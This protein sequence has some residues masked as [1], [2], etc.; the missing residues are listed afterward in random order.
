MSLRREV[1]VP[2]AAAARCLAGNED[3]LH[4]FTGECRRDVK[5]NGIGET[6]GLYR[7]FWSGPTQGQNAVPTE[8]RR[9][10]VGRE[11]VKPAVSATLRTLDD[12]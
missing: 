11:T 4:G 12:P 9:K 6:V 2:A 3:F 8:A 1:E 7:P 10:R 5:R